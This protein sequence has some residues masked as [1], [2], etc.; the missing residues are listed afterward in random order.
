MLRNALP[1]TILQHIVDKDMAVNGEDLTKLPPMDD[2]ARQMRVSRGKLREELVVAQAYGVVEMRPGDGTYVL[3]YDFYAAI[4]TAVLYGIALDRK[5]F[6]RFYRLRVQLE[7]AFWD[8]AVRNLGPEE[9]QELDA[10]LVQAQRKLTGPQAEIPHTEHRRFHLLI[11]SQLQNEFVQGL[12]EAYWDAY[13]AVGLNLY[14]DYSYYKEMW[15]KHQAITD[16]IKAQRYE[17]GKDILVNHFTLL[18]GRLQK[19]ED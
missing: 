5:N 19:S 18:E 11:F 15:S 6:D 17:G 1:Y 14:F 7:V 3:P 4:R 13:E 10:V 9:Y 16:A 8:E 2:L 12:L